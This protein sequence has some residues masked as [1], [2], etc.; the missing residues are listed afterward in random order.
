MKITDAKLLVENLLNTNKNNKL[1]ENDI[2]TKFPELVKLT[3][4]HHQNGIEVYRIIKLKENTK[5]LPFNNSESTTTKLYSASKVAKMMPDVIFSKHSIDKLNTYYLK[6]TLETQDILLDINLILPIL[7][8]KLFKHMDRYVSTN[9]EK[10][11]LKEAF[12]LIENSD[13]NEILANLENKEYQCIKNPN[14]ISH[15][16]LFLNFKHM[17]DNKD[18]LLYIEDLEEQY[19]TFKPILSKEEIDLCHNYLNIDRTNHSKFKIKKGA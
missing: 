12:S 1:L 10:I 15:F 2:I 6:F 19:N 8:E 3:R 5:I 13:E 14:T 18:T 17:Q 16:S 7:K 9:T 11:K 4:E